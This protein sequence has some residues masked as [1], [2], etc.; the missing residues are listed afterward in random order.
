MVILCQHRPGTAPATGHPHLLKT[1]HDQPSTGAA[2]WLELFTG[3]PGP[4]GEG[5]GSEPGT[6]ANPLMLPGSGG[7]FPAEAPS[8]PFPLAR[9][10]FERPCVGRESG[11]ICSKAEPAKTEL[12]RPAVSERYSRTAATALQ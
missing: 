1:P 9:L 5:I 6:Q 11:F 3:C 4:N 7:R 2:Q 10:S 8:P 12:R